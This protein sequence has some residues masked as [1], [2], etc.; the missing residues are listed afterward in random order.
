MTTACHGRSG[1]G[2][3]VQIVSASCSHSAWFSQSVSLASSNASTRPPGFIIRSLSLECSRLTGES[4]VIILSTGNLGEGQGLDM[5]PGFALMAGSVNSSSLRVRV[6]G[7]AAGPEGSFSVHS[8]GG[9]VGSLLLEAGGSEGAVGPEGSYRDACSSVG[10][11]LRSQGLIVL[12][13]CC[14]ISSSVWA[15]LL[16]C[17]KPNSSNSNPCSLASC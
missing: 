9:L 2:R 12:A 14:S 6:S 10:V 11:R 3:Q 7:K 8:T 4:V 16:R 15:W 5:V 13:G 17:R 1:R